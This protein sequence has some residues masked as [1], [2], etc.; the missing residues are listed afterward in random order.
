[1]LVSATIRGTLP[2]AAELPNGT[3]H[4][5]VGHA[6]LVS[7]AGAIALE[8]APA[9]FCCVASECLAENFGLGTAFLP[10]QTLGLTDHVRGKG[11]QV[12]TVCHGSKDASAGKRGQRAGLDTW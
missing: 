1:M 2:A 3:P 7:A 12:P 6:G 5:G 4:V 11:Q 8:A 10:G 9:L